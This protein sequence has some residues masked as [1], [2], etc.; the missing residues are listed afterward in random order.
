M[1]D[2]SNIMFNLYYIFAAVFRIM[3]DIVQRNTREKIHNKYIISVSH[4]D[5]HRHWLTQTRE[6]LQ[7]I[8]SGPELAVS[9]EAHHPL[10][11]AA[12]GGEIPAVNNIIN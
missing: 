9:R 12:D 7:D 6:C 5:A 8:L 2:F 4:C 10:D 11:L 3:A 1:R